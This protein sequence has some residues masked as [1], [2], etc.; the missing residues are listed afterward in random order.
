MARKKAQEDYGKSLLE[1]YAHWLHLYKNGG[2]DP[3]WPDGTN[4]NLVRNHIIYYKR[5]IEETP[6]LEGYPEAYHWGLPPRVPEHY[7]ARPDEIRAA[8]RE[9]LTRYLADPDYQFLC[10][11]VDSL[12]PKQAKKISI[13]NVIG[14][15]SGLERAIQNDD[16]VTMRRHEVADRYLP[17]FAS[18]AQRV[19]E[20][21][22]PENEQMGMNWHYEEDEDEELEW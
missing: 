13:H 1:S 15:A 6:T 14:Y 10:A 11:R 9:S 2:Q 20:L 16:L 8:A 19:R 21:K 17:A 12:D 22:P 4:I 7:M 5:M 18:C 3:G